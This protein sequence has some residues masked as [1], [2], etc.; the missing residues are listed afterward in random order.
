MCD[1]SIQIVN[2]NTKKYLIDCVEGVKKDLE[3]SLLA[4]EI[5]ILDNNSQDD[6]KDLEKKYPDVKFLYSD[7]NLGFGAGHNLL[8]KNGNSRYILILNPDIKL[9]EEATIERLF[10]FAKNNYKGV[11]DDIAVI[12]P[13]LLTQKKVQKWD[14][15]EFKGI[16]GWLGE[17]VGETYWRDRNSALEVAWVSGAFFLITRNAFGCVNGFDENFFLYKEEEDLCL[18]VREELNQKIFYY[19]EVKAFHYVSVAASK[20]KFM[21]V[22]KDYFLKKHQK[23]K[24]FLYKIYLIFRK[25]L[26]LA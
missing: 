9:I 1:I 15:G 20:S 24:G 17:K 26:T 23:R 18:R 10:H 21:R 13:K 11:C 7:K 14:H 5:L 25:I 12:G 2:Y 8:A 22:S 6:L 16:L 3:D 19:P 4:Y